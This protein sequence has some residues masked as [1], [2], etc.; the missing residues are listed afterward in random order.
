MLENVFLLE[1]YVRNTDQVAMSLALEEMDVNLNFLPPSF[2]FGLNVKD[3][4]PLKF[5]NF[6]QVLHVHAKV[7]ENGFMLAGP[8]ASGRL[9]ALLN[10]KTSS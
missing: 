8:Q 6:I 10:E 3:W 1:Q 2:D 9:K 7:D 5:D 4:N